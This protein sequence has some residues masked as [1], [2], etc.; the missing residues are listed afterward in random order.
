MRRRRLLVALL[1]GLVVAIAAPT[2]A[3]SV[4]EP[5]VPAPQQVK[6]VRV[7]V[8]KRVRKHV[9]ERF[10]GHRIYGYATTY[11]EPQCDRTSGGSGTAWGTHVY[12]GEVAN[13]S[14]PMGTWIELDHPFHGRRDFRVED[15]FGSGQPAEHL[16]VWVKCAW[17]T[18]FAAPYRT[19]VNKW[20]WRWR[21]ITRW[22]WRT[23]PV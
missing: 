12:F 4:P 5:V 10:H 19:F 8:T 20:R 3:N 2:I 11:S 22:V 7:K 9:L 21:T 13:D 23:V 15:T 16:D 17:V 18:S 14:L 6:Q 1:A